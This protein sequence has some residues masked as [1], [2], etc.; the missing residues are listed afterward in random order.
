MKKLETV[1]NKSYFTSSFVR[2]GYRNF[3]LHEF[4]II[5]LRHDIVK[6]I[7]LYKH[8]QSNQRAGLRRHLC[9]SKYKQTYKTI[10]QLK[11]CIIYS[12]VNNS[13][14]RYVLVVCH[15][16]Y[17][18]TPPIFSCNCLFPE[19]AV[20]EKLVQTSSKQVQLH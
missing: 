12:S 11:L 4:H 7:A 18:F 15:Q 2:M 16:Y 17:C 9:I 20:R 14:F 10:I 5:L 19:Q 3:I 6:C 13:S 1:V 8:K